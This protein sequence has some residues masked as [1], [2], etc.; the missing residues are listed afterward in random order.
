MVD[1]KCRKTSARKLLGE[2]LRSFTIASTGW[3]GFGVDPT[4]PVGIV[5]ARGGAK[6]SNAAFRSAFFVTANIL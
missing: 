2:R 3:S 5:K 6:G 1:V 4:L